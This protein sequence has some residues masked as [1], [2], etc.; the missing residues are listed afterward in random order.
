MHPAGTCWLL[1]VQHEQEDAQ[2]V[3][4][5]FVLAT[6]IVPSLFLTQPFGHDVVRDNFFAVCSTSHNLRVRSGF[7]GL[8]GQWERILLERSALGGGSCSGRSCSGRPGGSWGQFT[9][10]ELLLYLMHSLPVQG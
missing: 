4:V 9:G 6:L 2:K 5:Y 1:S 7:E 3:P 8:L 10:T